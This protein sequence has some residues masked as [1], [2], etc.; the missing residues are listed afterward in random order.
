M[1][2]TTIKLWMFENDSVSHYMY[3]YLHDV[4][5]SRTYVFILWFVS[6]INI[7]FQYFVVVFVTYEQW[8]D[9]ERGI[10]ITIKLLISTSDK[11]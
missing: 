10:D 7:H 11:L 4:N 8:Q 1:V 9:D 6:S 5:V 2:K 3:L